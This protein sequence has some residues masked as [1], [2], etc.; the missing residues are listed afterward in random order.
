MPQNTIQL[1]ITAA[2]VA[3]VLVL[4]LRRMGQARP[5]KVEQL[6]IVPVIY[7]V[8]AT[9]AMAQTP[10]QMSDLPWLLGAA[11]IGAAIGWYR[12][13]MMRITVD[14][15]T[16]ALNQQASPLALVLIIAVLGLRYLVRYLM[17]DD[18]AA[19]GVSVSVISD[20]PLVLVVAMFALARVEMFIRA[21]RLLRDARAAKAS[22]AGG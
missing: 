14:P 13:K 16:H 4:R 2:I 7:L 21:Q 11:L 10:P 17:A 15:E 20:A 12:G 1:I 6:W 5:L 18:S 9:G 3:L 22:A 8:A 19:L